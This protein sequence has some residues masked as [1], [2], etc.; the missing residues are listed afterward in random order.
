MAKATEE[1]ITGNPFARGPMTGS[2]MEILG[3]LHAPAPASKRHPDARLLE[4]ATRYADLE[5]RSKAAQAEHEHHHTRALMER[6]DEIS[7]QEF[8]VMHEMLSTPAQTIA[9][10][11]A[12]LRV[13][14]HTYGWSTKSEE[15][16]DDY[17]DCFVGEVLRDAERLAGLAHE[18]RQEEPKS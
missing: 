15:K 7:T 12:K 16:D 9:G 17:V 14:D 8:R 11:V 13:A 2:A 1:N 6:C 10:I 3:N 18:G 5:V 4:L